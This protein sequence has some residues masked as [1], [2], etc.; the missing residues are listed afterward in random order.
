MLLE[1]CICEGGNWFCLHRCRK[2][3]KVL[4]GLGHLLC[5]KHLLQCE[6]LALLKSKAF[7]LSK[8]LESEGNHEI[9]FFKSYIPVSPSLSFLNIAKWA[10]LKLRKL[11]WCSIP[12]PFSH[13]FI[14]F[15]L[16]WPSSSVR[17]P[18]LLLDG[19]A[20][21]CAYLGLCLWLFLE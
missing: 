15:L 17:V 3:H 21:A 6:L 16:D 11:G 5:I 9:L 14:Q 12:H 10:F 2:F 1:N 4:E 7:T 13:S 8:V 18:A 20:L 19:A